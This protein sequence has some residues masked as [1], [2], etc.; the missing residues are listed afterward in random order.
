MPHGLHRKTRLP[1]KKSDTIYFL[2]RVRPSSYLRG[3]GTIMR[4]RPFQREKSLGYERQN[5]RINTL[6]LGEHSTPARPTP[7]FTVEGR[8]SLFRRPQRCERLRL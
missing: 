2:T 7:E 4:I 1:I 6:R 8:P 5:P 3:M